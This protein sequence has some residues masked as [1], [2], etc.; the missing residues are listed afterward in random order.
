MAGLS[1]LNVGSVMLSLLL[2]TARVGRCRV[3]DP[4]DLAFGGLLGRCTG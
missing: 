2:S 3:G 1:D 4:A